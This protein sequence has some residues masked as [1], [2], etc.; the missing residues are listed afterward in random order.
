[1]DL[2]ISQGPADYI[3]QVERAWRAPILHSTWPEY[4]NRP[5]LG[6]IIA[7]ERPEHAGRQNVWLQAKTTLA[8]LYEA[9]RQ[10]ARRV[11]K[12]RSD[13]VPLDSEKLLELCKGEINFLFWHNWKKQYLLDYFCAGD[14]DLLIDLWEFEEEPE[15][16]EAGI[17]KNFFDKGLNKKDICFIGPQLTKENDLFWIKNNKFIS[18]YNLDPLYKN[19][20]V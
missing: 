1:M 20:Y 15:Y 3:E 14:I 17:T 13:M 10:G 19:N 18:D 11:V 12:I 16:P 6:Q 9:K 8:G 7:S 4:A 5:A 2:I